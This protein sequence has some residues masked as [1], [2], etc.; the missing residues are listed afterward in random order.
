MVGIV[1]LFKGLKGPGVSLL[2]GLRQQLL[3]ETSH[4][5]SRGINRGIRIVMCLGQRSHQT[6]VMTELFDIRTGNFV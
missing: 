1:H 4:V 2:S 5:S 3:M 6:Q